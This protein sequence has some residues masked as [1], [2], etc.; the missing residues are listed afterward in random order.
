MPVCYLC[1]VNILVCAG[2]CVCASARTR[3]RVCACVRA[4]VCVCMFVCVS[5]YARARACVCVRVCMCVCV[6]ACVHLCVCTCVHALMIV[7]L[8][9]ISS[10]INTFSSSNGSMNSTS[11]TSSM[12]LKL[13]VL[14]ETEGRC[15]WTTKRHT[16]G[17][18]TYCGRRRTG[19]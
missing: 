17:C 8:N 6:F 12:H 1:T 7:L 4:C 5:V 2:A 13:L 14:V 18:S 11:I 3:A 16:N 15:G 19:S 9:K 10:Q